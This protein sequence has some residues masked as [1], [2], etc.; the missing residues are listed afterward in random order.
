M[1]HAPIPAPNAGGPRERLRM[2]HAMLIGRGVPPAPDR[3]MQIIRECCEQKFGDALLFHA[4]LAARGVGRPQNFDDAMRYVAEAA[5]A[6]DTRAKGQYAALGGKPEFDRATWQAPIELKQHHAAPRVFTVENF[7]PKPA[8]AW[9]IKQARKNLVRAPVQA[10]E[11]GGAFA[12]DAARTNSVAGSNPLQPDLVL[13]LANLRMAAAVGIPVANQE[14]T[15]ILNYQ[16][17]EEYKPHF[18]FITSIEE[19][20]PIFARE[21][22][23]IGQRVVTVLVYLNEGYEGGET[24]FPLLDWRFK[25][26][27][28][29]ALI[30]WNLS[31]AGEG[32]RLSWHAGKPVTKGEKW[33][34]S[35]WV[36]QRPAPLG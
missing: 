16:R 27:T 15:N 10:P 11:K 33:L 20:Q 3:A 8:C 19:A 31:P 23:T 32:E 34:L 28:G 26:K 1:T 2:A 22:Q 30:F 29:D 12:I 7:L 18:D 13:Q 24:E 25:G 36:R 5:A 21:L 6:G 17:G 9:L 14:P 35:K 4:A